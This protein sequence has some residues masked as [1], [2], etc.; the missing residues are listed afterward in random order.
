MGSDD[1]L[2]S[3][4]LD[5]THMLQLTQ[6]HVDEEGE[7]ASHVMIPYIEDALHWIAGEG[8]C[9]KDMPD[10][11]LAL[12]NSIKIQVILELCTLLYLCWIYILQC[13]DPHQRLNYE[14]KWISILSLNPLLLMALCIS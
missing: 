14:N 8:Y 11:P 1:T 4:S 6:L 7:D 13:E 10:R 9:P 3:S 5:V 12:E 2:K